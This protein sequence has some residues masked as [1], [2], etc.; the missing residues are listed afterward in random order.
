MLLASEPLDEIMFTQLRTWEKM[1]FQDVTKAGLKFGDE[2][3]V[4]CGYFVIALCLLGTLDEDPEEEK[5][6]HTALAEKFQP[7]IDWLKNQTAGVIMDGTWFHIC[8]VFY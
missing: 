8:S 2:G 5:D 3:M 7:L 6:K 4:S 1:S